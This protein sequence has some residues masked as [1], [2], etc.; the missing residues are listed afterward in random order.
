MDRPEGESLLRLGLMAQHT[1]ASLLYPTAREQG[2]RHEERRA[3]RL[4]S[5]SGGR[6]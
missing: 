2:P 5:G 4:R 3:Q 1:E 6:R